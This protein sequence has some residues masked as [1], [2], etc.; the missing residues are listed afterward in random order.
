[1]RPS[2]FQ[3]GGVLYWVIQ[4]RNPDTL[5]LKDADSTPS[6]A[7]RKNGASVADSVT[8]TKRSATT[9][10]YDCSYNPAAEV[11]GDSFTLE[12]SATVTGTTTSSAT[13]TQTW[14]ARVV[15]VERGT[16]GANTTAPATPTNVSDAQTAILAKLPA[17]LESGR[18]A[19][20]LDSATA[21]KID[22]ILEDTGTTLPAAIAAIEGGGGQQ[23]WSDTERAQIRYR[24][25]LDGTATAPED[26][27]EDPIV[28]TPG[29]GS[30]TT[31]YLT[32]LDEA[33]EALADVSV[34]WK[35]IVVPDGDTG[36]AYD[37][38]QAVS[39][40]ASNGVAQ[41]LN[42]V[43]GATYG[44]YRGALKDAVEVTIPVGAGTTYELPSMRG[45]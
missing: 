2:V 38:S 35:M 33:G 4:T 6:V 7:V 13:Y 3:V 15:A 42:M 45:Y 34:Y 30:F 29:S 16:D 32:C 1:M 25:G 12:E 23:D 26:P 18:I 40:S 21:A 36:F 20:V 31:G 44:I 27:A 14:N 5:V 22:S 11:E 43:K 28:I 10:I 17:A 24:L 41:L 9:G 37:K 19:A 39:V 8:I